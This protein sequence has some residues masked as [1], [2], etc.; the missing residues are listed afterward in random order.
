MSAELGTNT[1]AMNVEVVDFWEDVVNTQ[2]EQ[3]VREHVAEISFGSEADVDGE[4]GWAWDDVDGKCLDLS[5]VREARQEEIDY[6]KLKGI[7]T[8]V[9]RDERSQFL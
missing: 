7:W 2:Q 5:K 4:L 6:M 1:D 9:D 8:E 3:E